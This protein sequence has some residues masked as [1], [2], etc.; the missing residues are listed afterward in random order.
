VQDKTQEFK[1][2]KYGALPVLGVP[3]QVQCEGFRCMAY[4]DREGRW[5]DLF[6]R[7]FVP[8]VLGVISG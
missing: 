3:V 2:D 6:S 5:V 7:E 1:S 4:R 8:R